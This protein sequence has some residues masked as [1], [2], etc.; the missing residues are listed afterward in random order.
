MLLRAKSALGGKVPS[1]P[2]TPLSMVNDSEANARIAVDAPK[3]PYL[4]YTLP[5]L[6]PNN[7]NSANKPLDAAKSE[8]K[9]GNAGKE[10]KTDW[11]SQNGDNGVGWND[12]GNKNTKKVDWGANGTWD[13]PATG[14]PMRP[15]SLQASQQGSNAGSTQLKQTSLAG[16]VGGNRPNT[17]PYN[18]PARPPTPDNV[19]PQRDPAVDNWDKDEESTSG[20]N[21]GN[22]TA[23]VW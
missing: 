13:G 10:N 23:T 2:A 15:A 7:T 8:P 21:A 1:P 4:K 5:A 12:D 22:E 6:R 17:D 11:G 18:T 20:T 9:A 16:I 14:S 19:A 3:R